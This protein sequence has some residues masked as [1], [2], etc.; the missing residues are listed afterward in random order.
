MSEVRVPPAGATLAAVKG[1]DGA[2]VL[3]LGSSISS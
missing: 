2:L 3:G 1:R